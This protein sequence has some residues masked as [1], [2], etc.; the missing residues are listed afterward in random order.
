MSGEGLVKDAGCFVC[1][2]HNERGLQAPFEIDRAGGAAWC[3]LALPDWTQ[4]W[5]GVVHG[6]V[7]ATLLDEACVHAGRTVGPQPVTV[8]LTVRYL[9]PVPVATQ[10]LVRA[11]VTGQRRR[12]V[13]TRARLEIDGEIH[14]EAEAKV[15]LLEASEQA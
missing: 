5:R 12:I 2:P 6:G 14:A 7:L 4:G 9:K 11:E 10:L 13:E 3:R 1:G 8:E 15:Y